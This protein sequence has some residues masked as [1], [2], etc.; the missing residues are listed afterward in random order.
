VREVGVELYQSMLEDAVKA[1]RSGA[2]DEK[3]VEDDWSPQINLGVGV[4]IPETYVEDLNTRLGLYRRL[5]GLASA[6]EREGFAAEL[7]DR[8]G[9]LPV[10][11]AQLMEITAVKMQCRALGIAKLDAGEKGAVF[12]FRQDTALDPVRLME[13]VR[14]RPN[15]LRLRPDSKLVHTMIAGAPEKRLALTRGF[16]KELEALAGLQPV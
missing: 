2:K 11:T 16:L 4:L 14:T 8:F 7:I 15:V 12:A 5:S 13:L 10:E 1:L 9:P 6:S 3:D